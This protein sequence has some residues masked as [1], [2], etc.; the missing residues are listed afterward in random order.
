MGLKHREY[1][2]SEKIFGC[3]VCKT[4][5][6]TIEHLESKVRFQISLPLS[7]GGGIGMCEVRCEADAREWV[8]IPRTTWQGVPLHERVCTLL[9]LLSLPSRC[10]LTRGHQGEHHGGTGGGPSYD[11]WLA[12]CQRYLLR[13]VRG[14]VGV[15]VW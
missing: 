10:R 2:T 11:Y 12:Y 8:A 3:H 15:E 13:Q 5:L 7:L 9:P 6:S 4:H 14:G 1:L